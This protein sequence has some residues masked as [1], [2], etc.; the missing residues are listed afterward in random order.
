MLLIDG[1]S[2]TEANEVQYLKTPCPMLLIDGGSL[3]EANEAQL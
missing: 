3:T 2:V 1:G